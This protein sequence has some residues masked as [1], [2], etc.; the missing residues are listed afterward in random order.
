MKDIIRDTLFFLNYLRGGD[1][2]FAASEG[3]L[4]HKFLVWIYGE[5]EP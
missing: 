4:K 5:P 2:T 3:T 1:G